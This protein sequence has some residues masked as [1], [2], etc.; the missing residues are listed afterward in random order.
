MFPL[1]NESFPSLGLEGWGRPSWPPG[2]TNTE[3]PPRSWGPRETSWDRSCPAGHSWGPG[4]GLWPPPTGSPPQTP[5]PRAP[6]QTHWTTVF[7]FLLEPNKTAV[8]KP[9]ERENESGQTP[10]R[11]G[12][13]W[14]LRPTPVTQPAP[15]KLRGQRTVQVRQGA[16]GVSLLHQTAG[17]HGHSRSPQRA[18]IHDARL[19]GVDVAPPRLGRHQASHKDG[20]AGGQD[21][22]RECPPGAG[23]VPAQLRYPPR[24]GQW[25]PGPHVAQAAGLSTRGRRIKEQSRSNT[26]GK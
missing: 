6:P 8:P 11:V 22:H 5:P 17:L 20:L 3:H 19:A 26:H 2:S 1:R 14:P 24:G 21:T 13:S 16:H 25:S 9:E 10:C 12:S 23:V 7:W 4:Q 18:S 15:S